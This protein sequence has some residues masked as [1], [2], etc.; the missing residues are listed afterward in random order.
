[1][2]AGAVCRRRV[3]D[4]EWHLNGSRARPEKQRRVFGEV[5]FHFAGVWLCGC[6]FVCGSVLCVSVV[7][8]MDVGGM[9]VGA[10]VLNEY[11]F[12]YLLSSIDYVT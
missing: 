2:L 10:S 4:L 7:I 11:N 3:I 12:N 6:V 8:C 9:L 5:R 1:M